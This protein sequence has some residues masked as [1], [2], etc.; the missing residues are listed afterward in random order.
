MSFVAQPQGALKS[1]QAGKVLC[2]GDFVTLF[3]EGPGGSG[4][5][6]VAS[7]GDDHVTVYTES[8]DEPPN[9]ERTAVFQVKSME[10]D[11]N[12]GMVIRYGSPVVLVHRLSQK[13]IAVEQAVSGALRRVLLKR[14]HT[15]TASYD[16]PCWLKAVPRIKLYDDGDPVLFN[17][18]ILLDSAHIR[19]KVFLSCTSGSDALVAAENK[20]TGIRIRLFAPFGIEAE[21]RRV[22][23]GGDFIRLFHQESD[24][25]L[26]V[27][28]H[29]NAGENEGQKHHKADFISKDNTLCLRQLREGTDATDVHGASSIWQVEIAGTSRGG[30]PV[31]WGDSVRLKHVLSDGYLDLEQKTAIGSAGVNASKAKSSL[32]V[33][34]QPEGEQLDQIGTPIE[35]SA[36]FYIKGA[37]GKW[38]HA[39]SNVQEEFDE[40]D[41]GASANFVE[42][43]FVET[44]RDEDA[45]N[46]QAVE[47]ADI[48][49]LS[50]AKA[51]HASLVK[52]AA[53]S[54]LD[55]IANDQNEY[56]VYMRSL[57]SMIRFCIKDAALEDESALYDG[58]TLTYHQN[59]LADLRVDD[60]LMAF[61]SKVFAGASRTDAAD[62]K[63]EA[64]L[65]D[66]AMKQFHALALKSYQVLRVMCKGNPNVGQ[67][68]AHKYKE[69]MT[70]QCRIL[71]KLPDI[72]WDIADTL[73]EMFRENGLILK[74]VDENYVTTYIN[75]IK[76]ATS[77]HDLEEYFVLLASLCVYDHKPIVDVQEA[78]LKQVKGMIPQTRIRGGSN[79]QGPAPVEIEVRVQPAATSRAHYEDW[80]KQWVLLDV[81]MTEDCK[82]MPALKCYVAM[83]ELMSSICFDRRKS[84]Q[85]YV[86]TH[87]APFGAALGVVSNAK[88]HMRVRAGFVQL[89][90]RVYV[91]NE[92]L[93]TE[94]LN[95]DRVLDDVTDEAGAKTTL[96]D[97]ASVIPER[98][99]WSSEL[100]D[101]LQSF[102]NKSASSLTLKADTAF[103]K[104][105]RKTSISDRQA[106]AHA[107]EGEDSTNL[108]WY[109]VLELGDAM[110]NHGFFANKKR[111]L[112]L[113]RDLIQLLRRTH[114]VSDA[115]ADSSAHSLHHSQR[116]VLKAK[117]VVCDI[118]SD[119]CEIHANDLLSELL[120]AFKDQL[121]HKK[122]KH[123]GITEDSSLKR[124]PM[125]KDTF[126]WFKDFGLTEENF[127]FLLMDLCRLPHEELRTSALRLMLLS[128]NMKGHVLELLDDVTITADAEDSAMLTELK[129]KK[130]LLASDGHSDIFQVHEEMQ[131]IVHW[132]T[133]QLHTGHS[134][135]ATH[136]AMMRHEHVHHAII[137]VLSE[138]LMSR[139]SAHVM[140]KLKHAGLRHLFSS[141]FHFLSLFAHDSEENQAELLQAKTVQ[142]LISSCRYAIRAEET[143]RCIM[144][145]READSHVHGEHEIHML[146]DNIF[147][148]EE[149]KTGSYLTMLQSV[150]APRDQPTEL[151][152]NRF[153]DYLFSEEEDTQSA[154]SLYQHV[155][156][157]DESGERAHLKGGKFLQFILA[158]LVEQA[159]TRIE[160]SQCVNAARQPGQN[161]AT[162]AVMHPLNKTMYQHAASGEHL[163]N[164]FI[165][166][167]YASTRVA[168]V[169]IARRMFATG[170]LHNVL[171]DE[172][173]QTFEDTSQ[174]LYVFEEDVHHEQHEVAV[175]HYAAGDKGQ[176]CD[177]FVE[178]AVLYQW[179][180]EDNSHSRH[181][182]QNEVSFDGATVPIIDE[183][184]HTIPHSSKAVFIKLA[185]A[186]YFYP[187][188]ADEI[189]GEQD[190][191]DNVQGIDLVV[192]EEKEVR[193]CP[194]G[195]I[196]TFTKIG[197]SL[198]SEI[199][200]IVPHLKKL[201]NPLLTVDP[202]FNLHET[203]VLVLHSIAPLIMGLLEHSVM[204]ITHAIA[205]NSEQGE[206]GVKEFQTQYTKVMTALSAY[207]HHRAVLEQQSMPSLKHKERHKGETQ[208]KRLLTIVNPGNAPFRVIRE[209]AFSTQVVTQIEASFAWWDGAEESEQLHAKYGTKGTKHHHTHKHNGKSHG[210]S[211]GKHG[212]NKHGRSPRN[213]H[214]NTHKS[215]NAKHDG[216]T[217]L[218]A[219]ASMNGLEQHGQE[220][221]HDHTQTQTEI[222]KGELHNFWRQ[223]LHVM[224]VSSGHVPLHDAHEWMNESDIQVDFYEYWNFV[225]ILRT[226]LIEHSHKVGHGALKHDAAQAKDDEVVIDLEACFE[227]IFEHYN[228]DD[229]TIT[230]EEHHELPTEVRKLMVHFTQVFIAVC[231]ME[232][233]TEK[234]HHE[235]CRVVKTLNQLGLPQVVIFQLSTKHPQVVTVAARLGVELCVASPVETAVLEN[236]EL[237]A[238]HPHTQL[239]FYQ[240]FMEDE[241]W[242]RHLFEAFETRCDVHREH[243]TR[244][245]HGHDDESAFDET[246]LESKTIVRMLDFFEKLLMGCYK[247]MQNLF[248]AQTNALHSVNM[249]QIVS[250]LALAYGGMTAAK[251]DRGSELASSMK[252]RE[253][254][255]LALKEISHELNEAETILALYK[256]MLEFV[257]GP[258]ADNQHV[259]VVDLH[260]TTPMLNIL[261]YMENGT[262]NGQSIDD[263]VGL[264]SNSVETWREEWDVYQNAK[265]EWIQDD[266]VVGDKDLTTHELE[267][268]EKLYRLMDRAVNIGGEIEAAILS[269]SLALVEFQDAKTNASDI[270]CASLFADVTHHANPDTEL[271]SSTLFMNLNSH[272]TK[273]HDD[274]VD[275]AAETAMSYYIMLSTVATSSAAYGARI[276]KALKKW[277]KINKSP[278]QHNVGQIEVVRN[279]TLSAVFFFIPP[280]AVATHGNPTLKRLKESIINDTVM[281]NDPERVREFIRAGPLVLKIM[282]EQDELQNKFF[283]RLYIHESKISSTMLLVVAALCILYIVDPDEPVSVPSAGEEAHKIAWYALGFSHA[284]IT[285]MNFCAY[286]G[287][288]W[289]IDRA[290]MRKEMSRSIFWGNPIAYVVNFARFWLF[291]TRGPFTLVGLIFSILGNA[292]NHLFFVFGLLDVVT[293]SEGMS[294]IVRAIMT[295]SVRLAST[296]VL[297]I[298][299]LFIFAAVGQHSFAGE[300]GWEGA[301]IEVKCATTDTFYDCLIGHI[302]TFGEA[303]RFAEAPTFGQFLFASIYNLA[304]VFILTGI[305]VGVIAD[306]FAYLRQLSEDNAAIKRNTCYVCGHSRPEL[307]DACPSGFNGHVKAEH[308]CWHFI[309]Y[310]LHVDT[311]VKKHTHLSGTETYFSQM[312]AKHELESVWPVGRALCIDGNTTGLS[313]VERNSARLEEIARLCLDTAQRVNSLN[314]SIAALTKL[315]DLEA[316]AL[317]H[318]SARGDV[319][320]AQALFERG[321]DINAVDYD[322]RS[323]LHIAA[324]EGHENLVRFLMANGANPSAKDRWGQTP[325]D[326]AKRTA[327][328]VVQHLAQGQVMTPTRARP[329]TLKKRPAPKF[330]ARRASIS[331][332]GAQ[333]DGHVQ[334]QV[335]EQFGF[336]VVD[337]DDATARPGSEGMQL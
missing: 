134:H 38:L 78:I 262:G 168:A 86:K 40:E 208:L 243:L 56:N 24:A 9:F 284:L 120:N 3:V 100:L 84:S 138:H 223:V 334:V 164:Y 2:H 239:A 60:T 91:D 128:F 68:V 306:S 206:S 37:E 209:K 278:F 34:I 106:A 315:S 290:H 122:H 83:L 92:H 81:A 285:L 140:E 222:V 117:H 10:T 192:T 52:M 220:H 324:A 77:F 44:K 318:A 82:D 298:V 235:Q 297:S 309:H 145:H 57:D 286:Y 137:K 111:R 199:N 172:E 170:M 146:I 200:A 282:H 147:H 163:V 109:T 63:L 153:V 23:K 185:T 190:A 296:V 118:L 39:S 121:A 255:H 333:E 79:K 15:N 327:P 226:E 332:V 98:P 130:K 116:V 317:L 289:T 1:A 197:V 198:E 27:D 102:L 144:E 173:D 159:A 64:R 59:T 11:A 270:L 231:S 233:D 150:V 268:V 20:K 99:L 114:R 204:A 85:E 184:F 35:H 149:C 225:H 107:K 205:D 277:E 245:S 115:S 26:E 74:A 303:A 271:D 71:G 252:T 62:A 253:L 302:Y 187:L 328:H 103:H 250:E 335:E 112:N 43:T 175:H 72:S 125:F 323:A 191:V 311:K 224:Q 274:D 61:V 210:K 267:E 5:A 179:C 169:E 108:F 104:L 49:Q 288:H 229:H 181:I 73:K 283:Q 269:T 67:H 300:Y 279:Q 264:A 14:T 143:L 248:H 51:D 97:I 53:M 96:E 256:V 273:R 132:L 80:S 186:L 127:C 25:L 178:L 219:I 215:K 272:H 166:M 211:H 90:N 230:G 124:L 174:E 295:S 201:A 28:R 292:H 55:T 319:A 259:L 131:E 195:R 203:D 126:I 119:L 135:D 212:T 136:R 320:Q 141:C 312:Q 281:L 154:M 261:M 158:T 165:K 33:F 94:R 266:T 176:A 182:L 162:S 8:Q 294:L 69:Q 326:E 161:G 337:S 331:K 151:R 246:D 180:A 30:A 110:V 275:N 330:T 113:K 105:D 19:G 242:A 227:S 65:L 236:K 322:M 193:V 234:A 41:A 188:D 194:I 167:N 75:M 291:S 321:V 257:S 32:V 213:T 123:L 313:G 155:G 48:Q 241:R 22:V 316:S 133:S 287:N 214:K 21:Y 265:D 183:H 95:L 307:E 29:D 50:K 157:V 305:V 216:F 54:R 228:H 76:E 218:A 47:L 329:G 244:R 36:P 238:L 207:Y 260:C 240:Q 4:Y 237:E 31:L 217:N 314:D 258:N 17:S 16:H 7:Y 45:F 70:N 93:D 196:R 280:V 249:L 87:I 254:P 89:I 304:V 18:Q 336:S 221:A 13:V 308:N 232:T 139:D 6:T 310:M 160:L 42:V 129:K 177:W 189:A 171:E 46:V 299:V 142:F 101:W 251:Q 88:V 12:P 148:H 263:F 276:Q 58:E 202:H 247:D 66:P 325:L 152:Q 301:G 156:A 293:K